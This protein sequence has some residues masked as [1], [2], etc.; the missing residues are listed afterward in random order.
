MFCP[1][2]RSY[3]T[4][5]GLQTETPR[6]VRSRDHQVPTSRSRA[7]LPMQIRPHS[8]RGDFQ[9]RE[10][11]QAQTN[12]YGPGSYV[13]SRPVYGLRG[14]RQ[15]L[16]ILKVPTDEFPFDYEI[17]RRSLTFQKVRTD[18]RSHV[19]FAVRSPNPVRSRFE[20]PA[21]DVVKIRVY[22]RGQYR[23]P[24]RQEDIIAEK[25]RFRRGDTIVRDTK[26][27][28]FRTNQLEPVRK[29]NS[30]TQDWDTPIQ[31]RYTR[32]PDWNSPDQDTNSPSQHWKPAGGS[33]WQ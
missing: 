3:F 10:Y 9:R 7:S 24:C 17:P 2:A 31:D 27:D 18:E 5:E 33:Q 25:V 1:C 11:G 23:S 19:R 15:P 6:L 13:K 32:A 14:Y 26:A 22:R 4:V 29:S 12:M 21:S 30:P 8:A 20:P 28:A 16:S